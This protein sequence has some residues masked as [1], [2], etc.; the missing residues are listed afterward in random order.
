M[1]TVIPD[2][3]PAELLGGFRGRILDA[4]RGYPEVI[5]IDLIDPAGA[6]WGFSTAD[7]DLLTF[8]PRRGGSTPRT[9]SSSP[10][11]PASTGR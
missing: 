11:V 6:K 9:A 8:G 2:I 1:A 4:Q 7:A 5:H 3:S 10:G